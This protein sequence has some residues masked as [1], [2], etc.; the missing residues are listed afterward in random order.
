MS[1]TPISTDDLAEAISVIR[2]R[3]DEIGVRL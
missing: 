3:I 1:I 2:T